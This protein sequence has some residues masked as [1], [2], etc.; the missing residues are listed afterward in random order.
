MALVVYKG[1]QALQQLPRAAQ[2]ALMAASSIKQALNIVR[3][4]RYYANMAMA[5][6]RKLEGEVRTLF[7]GNTTQSAPVAIG[8]QIVMRG[9]QYRAG[10]VNGVIVVSHREYLGELTG[11]SSFGAVSYPINPGLGESFPWLGGIA[12]SYE[13]Y[14]I[15]SMTYEYV[16]IAATSERGRVTLA[17]DYDVLDMVPT[18][19]VD[20]FQ[21]SGAAEGPI[22]EPLKLTVKPSQL[23]FT[24]NGNIT[25]ADLKTYDAGRFIA[26]CSNAA[27]TTVKG[28]LFVSYDIELHI[29]QSAKCPGD[30][31]TGSG[32]FNTS[33]PF[34]YVTLTGGLS[35]LS[36]VNG[37]DF[38]FQRPGVYLLSHYILGVAGGTAGSP[39]ITA[40]GGSVSSAGTGSGSASSFT[41]IATITSV[42]GYVRITYPSAVSMNSTVTTAFIAPYNNYN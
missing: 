17:V 11:S 14:K 7:A 6:K 9:P 4:T 23:L 16:N 34:Q 30:Y 38:V 24:R 12:N 1:T 41:T 2:V 40:N 5:T 39:T 26:A 36:I 10:N 18:N 21:I 20:L 37:S 25:G 13:K 35:G 29:P 22:W 28:E 32:M 3:Q 19:K 27:D 31:A 8:K 33:A 15:R 42:G